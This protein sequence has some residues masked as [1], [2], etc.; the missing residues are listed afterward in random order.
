M[1]S[2]KLFWQLLWKVVESRE[3]GKVAH[4]FSSH[5]SYELKSEKA[6]RKGPCGSGKTLCPCAHTYDFNLPGSH[7]STYPEPLQTTVVL[8]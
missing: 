2:P 6:G 4:A 8:Y 1:H 5:N 3:K 7:I